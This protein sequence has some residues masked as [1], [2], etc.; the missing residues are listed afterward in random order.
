MNTSRHVAMLCALF[1]CAKLFAAEPGSQDEAG[2]RSADRSWRI[3][4]D[5][6][7]VHRFNA[8]L[9]DGGSF[10]RTTWILRFSAT[11][12]WTPSLRAGLSLS[13]EHDSYGFDAVGEEPWGNIRT[14]GISLPITYRTGGSW[15]VFAL[16]RLR[17]SAETDADLGDGRE[18]GLLAGA[19]YRVNDRRS[20]LSGLGVFT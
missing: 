14:L 3:G 18:A 8:D 11:R 16:P 6:G 7:G 20:I 12:A 2:Q 1:A 15:S 13:Y 19:S 5:A 10:D 9:D 17:Y 4:L